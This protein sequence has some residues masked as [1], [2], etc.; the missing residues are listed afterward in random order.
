MSPA[1]RLAA[2][3]GLTL[4][5]GCGGGG[6]SSST[7]GT[8][9][10]SGAHNFSGGGSNV[11]VM[12]VG[13]G[14]TGVASTFNIPYVSVQVCDPTSGNCA[15]INNVLVDTGSTGFRI[16][17]S[18][19]NKAGVSLAPLPDPSNAA[20]TMAECLLFADGDAWGSVAIATLRVG[21]ETANS[22]PIQV[23]DDS[24]SPSPPAAASCDNS[25]N[26]VSAFDA[27]GILGV[28][29]SVQDCGQS[30][31]MYSSN[32]VYYS[33]NPAGNCASSVLD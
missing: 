8:N 16:V 22:I 9:T 3:L 33:C 11:V 2:V 25:L 1:Y 13:N 20:N 24:Q 17:K 15:T 31:A 23:I 32:G 14:P 21:G 5:A 28:G 30:C 26:S 4:L 12:T 27:N 18:V 6:G 29:L 10:T 7:S 19:L